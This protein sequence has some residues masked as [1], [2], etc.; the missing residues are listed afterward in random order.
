MVFS[1]K[2]SV[3]SKI[4]RMERASRTLRSVHYPQDDGVS[5]LPTKV[6][7]SRELRH[8]FAFY[9]VGNR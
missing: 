1:K 8:F 4:N 9:S 6:P 3:C 5:K 7:F 2:I